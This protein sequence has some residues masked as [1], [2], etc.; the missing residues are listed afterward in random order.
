M[1]SID[2]NLLFHALNLDSPKHDSAYEWL[3]SIQN[4]ENV[5]I[6]EFVLTEL[7]CLI[8][9]PTVLTN[10][11]SANEAA[12]VIANYRNHPRWR[13]IGFPLEGRVLHDRIWS[14]A[15]RKQFAYRRIYDLRTALTMIHKGV[16]ELA[17]ANVK[18]F[19]DLG[20][21]RVWNPLNDS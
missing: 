7:Y 14:L 15:K 3:V 17:T 4:D 20:F 13:L 18:D 8:R 12:R 16:R 11:M 1:L 19:K 21:R 10:P 6:S 2:T 5:A 9:N